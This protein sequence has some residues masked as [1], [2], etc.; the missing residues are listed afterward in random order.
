MKISE[1]LDEQYNDSALYMNYRNTSSFIDGQK[2]SSRKIIYAIKKNGLKSKMKVSA[3]AS[4]VVDS[5]KYLHGDASIQGVVVTAAQSFCG[6]NNLHLLKEEGA[7]GTRQEPAAAAPRYIFTTPED[8]FDKIFRKEDDAILKE[9]FFEGQKIE[10]IFYTP[11]VPLILVNGSIGVGVGYSQKILARDLKNMITAIR[12]KLKG[13]KNDEKLFYPSWNGFKGKV[14]RLDKAKW[15]ISGH[16]SGIRRKT[17]FIDELPISQTLTSY[18]KTLDKLKEDGVIEKYIDNCEPEKDNFAF[19]VTMTK[20][21]D[22]AKAM[23]LLKLEETITEVLPCIDENNAIKDDFTSAEEI[24]DA[25]FKI[26]YSSFEPRKKAEL[27]KLEEEKEY[28]TNCYNFIKAV[29]NDKLDI[30]KTKKEVEDYLTKNNYKFIDKLTSLPVYSLNSDKIEE[31]EQKIE[32]NKKEI[33]VLQKISP[34]DMW[35][36][37]LKEL[38]KALKK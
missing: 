3:F 15:K 16:I 36:K 23:K 1:F 4:K 8:Y 7:F 2:N 5:T 20:E 14:E 24:F 13:K 31:L 12:N 11:T 22:T 18:R 19:E 25:Y 28:L 38:E 10:P 27:N 9:Q 33:E 21:A 26:K 34:A 29:V 17:V 6:A 30:K 32:K 37:D 35:E